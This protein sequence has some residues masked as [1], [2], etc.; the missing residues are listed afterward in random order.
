MAE[1]PFGSSAEEIFSTILQFAPQ[2]ADLGTELGREQF[3]R[4]AQLALDIQ[5]EFTPQQLALALEQQRRFQPQF[6]DLQ[7]QL[8]RAERESDVAD[9]LALAPQVRAATEAGASPEAQ[10]IRSILADQITENLI[11]GEQLTPEQQRATEQSLRSAQEARGLGRGAG[12]A[13]REAVQLSL[14]GRRLGQQRRAEASQFAA[15]EAARSQNPFAVVGGTRAPTA[16]AAGQS[17]FQQR[18]GFPTLVGQTPPGIQESLGA[19]GGVLNLNQIQQNAAQQ[20]F[21]NQ[22][23]QRAAALAQQNL[24]NL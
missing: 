3:P 2:L 16:Q 12:S 5:R 8:R 9:V 1:N 20:G 23:R 19:I 13:N 21:E 10:R 22:M 15:Q 18:A 17:A 7:T 11:A 24:L 4:Q 14:Q 6:Q